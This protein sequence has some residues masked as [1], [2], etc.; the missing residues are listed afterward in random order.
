MLFG[1]LMPARN[2]RGDV[3]AGLAAADVRIDVGVPHGGQ[4]PQPA[5]GADD[6]GRVGRATG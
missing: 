3:D 2:E 4:P 6:D 5:R 1:G